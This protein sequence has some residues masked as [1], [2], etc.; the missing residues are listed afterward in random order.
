MQTLPPLYTSPETAYVID[1]YPYGFVLRCQK[2]V[3]VEYKPKR[4][5]RIVEQTSNPKRPGLVWNKPK[6]SVYHFL[7]VLTLDEKDHIG[8]AALNAVGDS[9]EKIDAFAELHAEGL[10]EAREQNALE[11]LRA[12]RRHYDARSAAIAAQRAALT[13]S[14]S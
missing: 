12:L 5:Y 11:F 14:T 6:A 2:R 8:I 9:I 7:M 1:D 3:W 10:T 13:A 4:G